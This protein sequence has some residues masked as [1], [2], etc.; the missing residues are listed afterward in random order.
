MRAERDDLIEQLGVPAE[1]TGIAGALL[2]WRVRRDAYQGKRRILDLDG[3][4]RVAEPDGWRSARHAPI[5]RRMLAA[6]QNDDRVRITRAA[7]SASE[8]AVLDE[9]VDVPR[10]NPPIAAQITGRRS[11]PGTP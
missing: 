9:R 4:A 5:V 7:A 6:H 10:S 11:D 8:A 1:R 3:P 2:R